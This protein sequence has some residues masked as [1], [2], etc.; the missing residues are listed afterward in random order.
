MVQR[1][2]LVTNENK[3]ISFL[4]LKVFKNLKEIP[5]LLR[6]R[7]DTIL[8]ALNKIMTIMEPGRGIPHRAS[9]VI[10]TIQQYM[11]GVLGA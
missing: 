5:D 11:C 7:Y 9:S 1:I 10:T 4:S 3:C 8:V 2:K 6:R